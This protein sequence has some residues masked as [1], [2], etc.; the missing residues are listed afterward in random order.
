MVLM[1]EAKQLNLI[2]VFLFSRSNH[3]CALEFSRWIFARRKYQF[4]SMRF[5]GQVN[6]D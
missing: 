2:L 1:T 6:G 4:H 5:S 3:V